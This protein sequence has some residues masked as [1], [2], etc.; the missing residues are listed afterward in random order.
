MARK[1]TTRRTSSTL[2][3]KAW[4]VSLG[5]QQGRRLILKG[6]IVFAVVAAGVAS[7]VAIA[8]LDD[9]VDRLVV[10]RADPEIVFVALPPE[11]AALAG[12]ELDGR[13]AGFLGHRWTDHDL[14]EQ[15]AACLSSSGW[16]SRVNYVRR[17]SQAE[18]RVSCRYR[19]PR[20]ILQSEADFFLV[21]EEAVRLPGTYT[22]DPTWILIQGVSEPAPDP[23]TQ[24]KGED[25]RAG[26]AVV[27]A[28]EA[29]SFASQITGVLVENHGGRRDRRRSHIELA[30]DRAGGRIRWG[31]A[32]GR[33]LE[34][35]SVDQKLAILRENFR[36]TGR[37]DARYPVIDI[38][39]FADRFTVPD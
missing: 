31:S 27:R 22:Y 9:H 21:D 6:A 38:A 32:P 26:L 24:W 1:R 14:P 11:V 18:F 37:V 8:H 13:L 17:T 28:L 36:R 29:E 7:A 33:E 3:M 23:G 25:L 15:M 2:R 20:A 4:W 5:G 12:P 19:W 35:N 30:T 39:T 10:G 16:V 34:E